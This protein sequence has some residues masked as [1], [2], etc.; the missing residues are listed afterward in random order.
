VPD[1][2]R[3]Y[4]IGGAFTLIGVDQDTDFE[5]FA[6]AA[7]LEIKEAMDRGKFNDINPDIVAVEF[8]TGNI[9]LPERGTLAP[10]AIERENDDITNNDTAPVTWPWFVLGCGVLV[11]LLCVFAIQR[12]AVRRKERLEE[13]NRSVSH[14]VAASGSVGGSVSTIS[15]V[16][17]LQATNT[18]T[19]TIKSKKQKILDTVPENL[20]GDMGS[21]ESGASNSPPVMT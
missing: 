14:M 8:V 4:V 19:K 2:D 7:L 15:T 17:S 5:W 3:C 18:P 10:G 6:P 1:A 16:Q 12:W 20:S 13:E 9:T 21:V 11:F